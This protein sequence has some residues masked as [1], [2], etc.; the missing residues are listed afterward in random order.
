[1]HDRQCP[2]LLGIILQEANPIHLALPEFAP[3]LNGM[4]T[5]LSV[6]GA[7]ALVKEFL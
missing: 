3:V 4:K 7:N 6:D 5:K 2:F 1:M